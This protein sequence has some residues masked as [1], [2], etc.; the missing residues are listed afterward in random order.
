MR[1]LLFL[2]TNYVWVDANIITELQKIVKK[3]LG[4]R[5]H[6]FVE[7][8]SFKTNKKEKAKAF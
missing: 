7:S 1:L 6:H 5:F 3:N 2:K 8:E 4:R